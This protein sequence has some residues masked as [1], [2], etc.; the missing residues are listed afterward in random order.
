MPDPADEVLSSTL[1]KPRPPALGILNE[2]STGTYVSY[3]RAL[4]EL[5]SNAW[6]ARASEV[7]ITISA[8]LNEITIL[9][10][11]EGMSEEDIRERFLRI[12]GSSSVRGAVRGGRRLIGHKGI[13]ALSVIPICREVRVL[14]TK[15]NSTD[16]IEAVLDVPRM[17]ERAKHQEDLATHYVY[18]LNKWSNE[19]SEKHY[20]FISL[21]NLTP[22]IQDFL[23]RKGVTLNQYISSVSTELSGIEQLKWE[24]A[25]LSPVAYSK[26]GPFKENITPVRK[27]KKELSGSRFSVTVNNEPL[28]KPIVL[29][30]PDIKYTAKYKRGTDYEIYPIEHSDN[31]LE[32]R[33]YIFSQATAIMPSDLRGGLIRVNNVA[34]G[35]Y[36]INWMKYQKHVGPRLGLTTGEIYV[37]K[38]LE[39]ALLIERDRFR[40]TDPLFKRFRDI[41][42]EKLKESFGGAT[43]RSRKRARIQKEKQAETFREKME[44]KVSQYLSSAYR[45]K[46][47]TLAF[48]ELGSKPPF[49]IDPRRGKVQLNASHRIFR[50]LD[51]DEKEIVEAFLI[52]IGIA[53]ERSAGDSNRML[54]E[55]FR[56]ITD[57]LEARNKR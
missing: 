30:S 14:T 57:L 42:H 37:Y 43:R 7:Q 3:S 33:G 48:E 12:G 41:V 34:I 56:I 22:E 4:K 51:E 40:E 6:D 52:A 32:F 27:I 50:K 25:M 17:I 29:P 15:A 38:G 35:S 36:D 2:L 18:T 13:G 20:T 9:D 46:P 45:D 23:A 8:D 5:L 54:E 28:F 26:A 39:N 31:E 44:T 21:R 53:K 10:N 55:I 11:G 16:R 1:E 47:V 24:L 19:P 49:V